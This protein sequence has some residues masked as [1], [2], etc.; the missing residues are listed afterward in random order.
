MTPANQS[1]PSG[2]IHVLSVGPFGQAVAAVLKELLPGVV[3][4]RPQAD[5]RT[6]SA[7]WPA[8]RVHLLAAWRPTRQ[9]SRLFDEMSHAWGTPFIEAVMEAPHLR[10]GPAVVPGLGACHSCYEKRVFQHAPRPAGHAALRDFYDARPERG[11]RGFLTPFAEIAALRLAQLVSQLERDR[12]GVA[13]KIW[14]L[15]MISRE[16]SSGTVV[17]IHGCSRCG[18]KRPEAA[19][20][21]AALRGELLNIIGDF[22]RRSTRI[23]AD[24]RLDL[25]RGACTDKN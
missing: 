1:S 6:F 11:P 14:Q 12:V 22:G 19:R 16:P 7:L 2:A 20:S 9:L 23:E 18:L 4:T 17:G 25:L 3:E 8:A 5:G 21:F 24:L 10:V 13:G 15:N